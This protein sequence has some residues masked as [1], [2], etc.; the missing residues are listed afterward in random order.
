MLI[1]YITLLMIIIKQERLE[2][3]GFQIFQIISR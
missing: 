3:L 2:K 1:L